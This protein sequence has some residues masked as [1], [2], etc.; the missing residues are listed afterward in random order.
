MINPENKLGLSSKSNFLDQKIYKELKEIISN[1]KFEE[2]YQERPDHYKHVFKSKNSRLNNEEDTYKC[3]FDLATDDNT[4]NLIKHKILP[5]FISALQSINLDLNYF[6]VPSLVRLRAGSF[7]RTHVDDY[8]GQ[9]GYTYFVNDGWKWDYGGI[10]TY[11]ESNGSN[12][13][14]I[15]PEDN[16]ILLRDEKIKAFHYVTQQM[17]YSKKF[18]YLLLGWASI[19]EIKDNKIRNY[20]KL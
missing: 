1:A 8:A 2:I 18:Q 10:L 15:F 16:M 11:L 20:V 4:I 13:Y 5:Y 3:R 12:S 9:A 6:M 19:N 7:Y 14:P 17:E